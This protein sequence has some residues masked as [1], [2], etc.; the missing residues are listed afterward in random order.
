[1]EILMYFMF[2]CVLCGTQTKEGVEE[3]SF[4]EDFS[5]DG[6]SETDYMDDES[7]TLI[8]NS[9]RGRSNLMKTI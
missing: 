1:M 5:S 6:S 8:N 7:E 4:P 3:G 2:L 9:P